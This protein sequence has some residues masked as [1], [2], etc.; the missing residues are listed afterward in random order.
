V[1]YD[2]YALATEGATATNTIA[3]GL[4]VASTF[5]FGF[6]A[7]EIYRAGHAAVEIGEHV[8]S[9]GAHATEASKVEREVGSYTNTHESG[10]QYH[11]KGDE[12]RAAQSGKEKANKYNDPV[13][14]TDW[15]RAANDREAFKD[16]ARRLRKDDNGGPRG[17]DNPNNYNQRAS[18]GEKYLRQDG[19]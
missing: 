3:L 9:Q 8:A 11:G 12:E 4:D 18:P 10:K 7:G 15:K 13:V 19:E 16:E 6:G 1:A 2:I 17:H 14:S 5:G